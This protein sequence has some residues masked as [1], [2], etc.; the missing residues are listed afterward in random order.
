MNEIKRELNQVNPKAVVEFRVLENQIRDSMLRERLMA[1]LTGFFGALAVLI[2]VVGLYGVISY[3]VACRRGEI[4]IRM[5][6]GAGKV[7]IVAM[8]LRE[9]CLLLAIG[10][11]IGTVASVAVARTVS[12]ILF[13]LTPNDATT[14]TLAVAGLAAVALSASYFPARRAARLE[15]MLALR[16]E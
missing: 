8:I 15:P 2:A 12:S 6:L 1:T 13:G 4:G 9:A 5:A 14:L 3:M 11:A 10:L 7:S 16:E